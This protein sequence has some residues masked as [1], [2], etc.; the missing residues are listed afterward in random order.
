M[1]GFNYDLRTFLSVAV[2]AAVNIKTSKGS[3]LYMH[4]V[5]GD[6]DVRYI[7]VFNVPAASVTLGTTVPVLVL[8]LP[9][10]SSNTFS[11]P[12]LVSLEGTGISV[13]ATTTAT[14]NTTSTANCVVNAL[15][16]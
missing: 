10:S 7:Q 6:A 16:A 11:F 4:A 9:A 2:K 15:F 14:G 3:M 13:A 8:T 5:N 12:S 1:Q